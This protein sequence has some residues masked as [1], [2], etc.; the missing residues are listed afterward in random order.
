MT[1]TPF[2]PSATPEPGPRVE[3]LEFGEDP[4]IETPI[5][6]DDE[7]VSLDAGAVEPTD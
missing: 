4:D 5:V 6:P 1:T 7:D 2:E 3:D